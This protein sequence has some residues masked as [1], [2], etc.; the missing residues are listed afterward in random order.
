MPKRNLHPRAWRPNLQ[1]DYHTLARRMGL[2]LLPSIS[3]RQPLVVVRCSTTTLGCG[4]GRLSVDCPPLPLLV[5]LSPPFHPWNPLPSIPHSPGIVVGV[6]MWTANPQRCW[7]RA[8]RVQPVVAVKQTY[9]LLGRQ[10]SPLPPPLASLHAVRSAQRQ[11]Y[12]SRPAFRRTGRACGAQIRIGSSACHRE[13][14]RV[15]MAAEENM[16]KV[17]RL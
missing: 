6:G 17:G 11:S 2:A 16:G 7:R 13:C 8:H 4:G 15:M 9:L 14:V 5:H 10:G 3:Q 1:R 12:R